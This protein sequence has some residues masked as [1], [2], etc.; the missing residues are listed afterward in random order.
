VFQTPDGKP[1]LL[2]T[3]FKGKDFKTQMHQRIDPTVALDTAPGVAPDPA[4]PDASNYCV[5]W[6]GTITPPVTGRYRFTARVDDGVHLWVDGKQIV[7]MWE[8]GPPRDASGSIELAAGKP[9]TIRYDFYQAAGGAFASLGWSRP[10]AVNPVTDLARRCKEDGTTL[11]VLE[12]AD[13]W[14]GAL[15][16]DPGIKL[17]GKFDIG[18][19][20]VGGHYFL[21]KHP[22]FA[23]LPTNLTLDWQYQQVVPQPGPNRIGLNIEG[24]E[25]IVGAYNTWPFHLGTSVGV[26]KAGKGRVLFSTLR[27]ADQLSGDDSVSGVAKRLLLNFINYAAKK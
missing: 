11:I 22:L 25:L 2:A 18:D 3:F 5:R 15:P 4:V 21:R 19:V 17:G 12:G 6:E 14:L 7:S 23:G 13:Q 1:G 27:I 16:L 10:N 20:W 26:A 24:E 9:V 8:D